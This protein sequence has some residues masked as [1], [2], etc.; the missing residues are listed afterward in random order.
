MATIRD[1]VVIIVVDVIVI[2]GGVEYRQV[3]ARCTRNLNRFVVN[4]VLTTAAAAA[5]ATTAPAGASTCA[6]GNNAMKNPPTTAR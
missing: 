2:D 5:S 3:N 1:A 6:S 4:V